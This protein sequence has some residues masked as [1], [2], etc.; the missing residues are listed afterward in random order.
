MRPDTITSPPT[1]SSIA[2]SDI[3]N[4]AVEEWGREGLG[5]GVWRLVILDF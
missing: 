5:R 4:G 1:Y 2:E 3:F